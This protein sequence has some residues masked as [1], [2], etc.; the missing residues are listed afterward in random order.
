MGNHPFFVFES[1]HMVHKKEIH[2]LHMLIDRYFGFIFI[3][4]IKVDF[5]L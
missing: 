4:M 3:V 1:D 5:L 2:S